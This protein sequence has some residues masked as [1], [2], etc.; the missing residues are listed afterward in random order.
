MRYQL[1]L[2]RPLFGVRVC[3]ETAEEPGSNRVTHHP[4]LGLRDQMLREEQIR[5]AL[6]NLAG[7]I[8]ESV[9]QLQ[10]IVTAN[11]Q[12]VAAIATELG[13]AIAKE[14][15][16]Q[17][18]DEGRFDPSPIVERCLLNSVRGSDR[19]DARIELCPDD[20]NLVVEQ[21]QANPETRARVQTVEFVANP[22][23]ERGCVNVS[24]QSGRLVY[25]PDEVL[26]R[27]C[28]EIRRGVAE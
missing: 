20:L 5:R 4:I 11:V 14:I 18:V 12:Q 27:I 1:T 21:L 28:A 13:M 25:D 7:Q 10:P 17:A 16:G 9:A 3:H 15:V 26:E 24:S 23:M 2:E 19:A 8:E 6:I 22:A